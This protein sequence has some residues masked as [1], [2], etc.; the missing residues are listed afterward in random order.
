MSSNLLKN[1]SLLRKCLEALNE[2][3]LPE[4][5]SHILSNVFKHIVPITEW[6]KVDWDKIDDKF[7]IGYDPHLIIPTLEKLLN[8]QVV[9][10]AYIEWNIYSIP[11]IK[12][13][14]EDIIFSFKT[15]IKVSEEK[16]IFNPT[17]GYIVEI[18]FGGE[19]TVGLLTKSLVA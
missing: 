3:L 14:L 16:F 15:I 5:E 18:R 1:N 2:Q 8:K 12:A 4:K 6:G 10:K 7:F 9:Q 13:D 11:V 17:Q 19:I